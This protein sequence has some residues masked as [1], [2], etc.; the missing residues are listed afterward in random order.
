MTAGL[1]THRVH[2]V[3]HEASANF[4]PGLVLNAAFLA[5]KAMDRLGPQDLV[6]YQR[7]GLRPLGGV[8][9]RLEPGARFLHLATAQSALGGQPPYDAYCGGAWVM[10]VELFERVR[11]FS[12]GYVGFDGLEDDL[13]RR[14]ELIL[15]AGAAPHASAER[16][17]FLALEEP[18]VLH[19][20][21]LLHRAE[22]E[23]LFR[24]RWEAPLND[25][26]LVAS[27]LAGTAADGLPS[28]PDDWRTRL[29]LVRHDATQ[30]RWL[31]SNQPEADAL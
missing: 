20:L 5:A 1:K 13:C 8:R 29:G 6:V 14:V 10:R 15:G 16:G 30:A 31:Y 22:N 17:A 12:K 11:G 24:A 7:P 27:A 18:R 21:D 25:S 2:L 23:E 4:T 3:E 19:E 28:L 26:A 9:Y